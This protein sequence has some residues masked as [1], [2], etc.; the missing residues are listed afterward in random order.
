MA[1]EDREKQD[2]WARH[3]IEQQKACPQNYKWIERPGGYQCKGG[4][5]GISYILITEG[6]CGVLSL[7]GEPGTQVWGQFE[8]IYYPTEIGGDKYHRAE[9]SEH[10]VHMHAP[11]ATWVP[12]P[13][14]KQSYPDPY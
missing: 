3:I 11:G 12:D 2:K 6:K 4:G 5:H 14:K 10:L 13:S 8:S 1:P 7:P 9:G